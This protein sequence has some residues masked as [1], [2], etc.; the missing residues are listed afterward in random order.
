MEVEADE[1]MNEEFIFVTTS[2]N[3]IKE[4]QINNELQNIANL[5]FENFEYELKNWE[6]H[7][8]TFNKFGEILEKSLQDSIKKFQAAFW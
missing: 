7:L 1:E 8:D 3:K 5:F 4:E 2:S 6:L